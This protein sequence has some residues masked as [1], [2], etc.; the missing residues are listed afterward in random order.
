M[1]EEDEVKIDRVRENGVIVYNVDSILNS[2]PAKRHLKFLR[3][4]QNKKK[5]QFRKNK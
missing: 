5:K 4:S 2:V 3:K 1:C